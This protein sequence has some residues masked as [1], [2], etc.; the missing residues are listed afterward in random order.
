MA[1]CPG[2]SFPSQRKMTAHTCTQRP[3]LHNSESAAFI[4][5]TAEMLSSRRPAQHSTAQ[6]PGRHTLHSLALMTAHTH[7]AGTCINLSLLYIQI[8]N[9]W[10]I[11]FESTLYIFCQNI[12]MALSLTSYY[13]TLINRNPKGNLGT[14]SHS[15]GNSSLHGY[16]KTRQDNV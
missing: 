8:E 4:S 11:S 9:V 2:T 3:A 13:H 12:C 16:A 5:C 1:L 15:S 6:P 10:H 7:T 14:S